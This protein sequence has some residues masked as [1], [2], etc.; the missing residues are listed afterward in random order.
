LARLETVVVAIGLVIMAGLIFAFSTL[1][2]GVNVETSSLVRD[3]SRPAD[4]SERSAI[5]TPAEEATPAD[6]SATA[7]DEEASPPADIVAPTV[8]ANAPV[9]L[10]TIS[11]LTNTAREYIQLDAATC[12]PGAGSIDVR[13]GEVMLQMHG[14]E[15]SDCRVDYATNIDG[16]NP[17]GTWTAS[18]RIPTKA[19]KIKLT[20]RDDGADFSP[21]A[22]FCTEN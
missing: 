12:N 1:T 13:R 16:A 9:V 19:G 3:A 8:T 5:G 18:C 15:G 11:M 21:I 6:D 22:I 10:G 14:I 20:T 7:S 17:D 2:S 4:A